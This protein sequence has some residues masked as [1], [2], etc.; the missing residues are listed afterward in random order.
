MTIKNAVIKETFIGEQSGVLTTWVTVDYGN[1]DCQG[2]GGRCL[3]KEGR[4]DSYLGDTLWGIMKVV[5]V[6]SW[7]KLLTQPVRVKIDDRGV[8]IAIGHFLQDKWFDPD[9]LITDRIQ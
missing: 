1:D 5:G 4:T 3:H 2:F 9:D 6:G 8:I 7:N